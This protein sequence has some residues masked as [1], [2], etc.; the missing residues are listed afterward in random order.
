MQTLLQDIRYGVRVLLKGRTVTFVAIVALAL[1][2]GANTAIFSVVNALLFRSLPYQNPE[3]LVMIWETNSEVQIGFD[4]LPVSNAAFADWHNQAQSFEAVS[5]LDSQRYAFTG[6]GQPE[7][8]GGVSTSAS[9]F[10][11]MGVSPMLGRAYTEDEDRPGANKVAVISYALWQSR[12]GG[13]KEIC[14]RT[15]QLDGSNYT[16]LG[17]MPQGFQFPRATDLPSLFQLPPQTELWTP[18]GMSDKQ[19]ANRGSHN[20]AVIARLK[21]G[22][23]PEQAQS[24]LDAITS[25]NLQQ[26]PESQGWGSRLMP[27]KEQLVGGLR[28]A[29]LILLGA[30]G[31][32]LLIACANV[33]NL[34]LARAAS[35]QKE[36]AVRTALGAS[37]ARLVRQLLT[38]SV[39]LAI[40]GGGIAVLLAVWGIDLLL[41]VSPA[42]IPRKYE[43]RLDG[44]ALAFT[45]TVALITGVL[46]GLAPA[47]Q[48]S[49]FNLNE[50][51]K[52]GARG[53]TGS[54]NRVRSLLVV[55][56]V[57]LS[58]VLLI[59]AGLL[60]RSFAHLMSTDPGFNPR[61]VAAMNL[62]ASSSQ[63]DA[64]A[65]QVRFFKQVLEKVRAIPG[66]VA[67]GAVSE[68]PLGGAEEI[69]QFTVEGAPPPKTLND[70]PLADYRFIDADYL[71]TLEI[72]LVAGRAFT[73][74]DNETA[75]QVVII[76][77]TLARR[78]FG[79]QPAVGKRLKAGAL[80]DEA[81]WATIVGVVKDIKHTG[82]DADIRPQL[83]FPYQQK[84]WGRMVIVARSTTDAAGLF[85]AMR[86]AVWAVDKD[87][88]I[89]SLRTMTDFLS[90]S[91]SQQRFNAALLAAFAVLALILASVGIYGVMSYSVT[92]RTHELGI[93]MALGAK[94]RDV[95]RMVVMEGMRLAMAGVGVGI[96]LAGAFA[97]TRVMASLLFGV[98]ATDPLTFA[99]ISLILTGVALAAC[100]VP[101]R[102]ATR[103]DP[104][105]ALR[106]E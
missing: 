58:L 52:E 6:A 39:L 99:L 31:L 67:A 75:P 1:G 27:L 94:P 63:Y 28:L 105:I 81:P 21:A 56:E 42:G 101:A 85:P 25:R 4:L 68:L 82:L 70:T 19:L 73:E 35:R 47:F 11:V 16:I 100:F 57:A 22:V 92:Q 46:F 96:G 91:V 3:R 65:R 49:R 32:V 45:F 95:F 38:E 37:R 74:Y 10:D 90:D 33:A 18:A 13:D 71:K 14:G 53:S 76:G 36:M 80:E 51:L 29:L 64:T 69:D 5:V 103:V 20:K 59:G 77:E 48:V 44:A 2:I 7:R 60:I 23:G 26:F 54:R 78:Y 8:I 106:Y 43:I 24:E 34:L 87:Q 104:M 84:L 66:V 83:Y 72:P 30:V 9:F 86:E 89:T 15:M 55:S 50:T 40:V 93:R 41:A 17:V 88:P 79:D 12:F 97:A 98:S 102:R 62:S 61:N